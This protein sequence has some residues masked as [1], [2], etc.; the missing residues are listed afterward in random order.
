MD[1]EVVQRDIVRRI[2]TKLG[3]QVETVESGEKAVIASG[4]SESEDVKA[5]LLLGVSSF[6]KKPYKLKTL[7]LVVKEVIVGSVNSNL[8][9]YP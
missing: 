5:A 9:K 8:S 1:D 3:Y 4:F 6:I 2:L 7:G